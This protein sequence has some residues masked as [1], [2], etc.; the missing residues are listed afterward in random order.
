MRAIVAGV[1]QTKSDAKNLTRIAAQ[2]GVVEMQTH[3]KKLQN[4]C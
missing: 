3:A 2:R 4:S 1:F